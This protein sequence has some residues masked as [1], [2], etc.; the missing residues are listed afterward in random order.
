MTDTR[1]TN[2]EP[3]PYADMP[4]AMVGMAGTLTRLRELKNV[5]T[6]EV[7]HFVEDINASKISESDKESIGAIFLATLMQ[8]EKESQ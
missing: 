3:I 4:S 8:M 6:S 5:V 2:H 7:E 1:L